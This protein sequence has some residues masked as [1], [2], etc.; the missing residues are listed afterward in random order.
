MKHDHWSFGKVLLGTALAAAII[1]A[2]LASPL[3]LWEVEDQPH[4]YSIGWRSL[5]V[6]VAIFTA[7]QYAAYGIILL[8]N[9]LR[10]SSPPSS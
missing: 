1:Y 9:R 10:A 7:C 3:P 6:G 2:W 4:V 8:F 5:I